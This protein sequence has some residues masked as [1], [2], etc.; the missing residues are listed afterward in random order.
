MATYTLKMPHGQFPGEYLPN[1]WAIDYNP[2]LGELLTGGNGKNVFVFD[3]KPSSANLDTIVDFNVKDDTIWLDDDVFTKAGKVGGLSAGAFHIGAKA[4]D[5]SDRVLYDKSTGKLFYD[6][7][8]DG[9][10][11]AVQIALL[12]KG[13]ALTASDFDIIA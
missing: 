9:G 1:H 13:L 12:G 6:A 5:A 3:T 10:V 11:A 4:H 8:G 2:A 7:D